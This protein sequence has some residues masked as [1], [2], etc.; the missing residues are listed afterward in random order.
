MMTGAWFA[1]FAVATAVALIATPLLARYSTSHRRWRAPLATAVGPP[2]AV[3]A[4]LPLT[5][6]DLDAVTAIALVGALWLWAA[7]Q[8]IDR[9]MLPSVLR[10]LAIGAAAALV[11]AAGLRLEVTGV[12]WA[13]VVVTVIV[14]WAATSAWRSAETR[15]GLLLG[16][17]A[18][19]AAGAALL[20]GL[21][22][23]ADI[24]ELGFA[25]V[26]AS[27]GFLAYVVPPV[28]ARLRTGGA[29]F[30]GFLTIVLAIA[31]EPSIEPPIAA[32]ASLLLIALP[33]TDGV[34]TRAARLRGHGRDAHHLGLAGRW[35]A[36]GLSRTATTWGLVV[37]QA[38]LVFV[39][40]LV[41]RGVLDPAPALL[42][43]IVLLG[44]VVVPA[45]FA[46]TGASR[47]RWPR[48]LLGLA[49]VAVGAILLLAAPAALALL[50]ARSDTTAAASA[51]ER[52]LAAARRGE[53]TAAE[54][55]FA[56]AARG[57]TAARQRLNDPAASLG[58][59]IPVLGPNLRAARD[60]VDVG[61]DLAQAGKSLASTADPEQLRI[62]D[63]TVNLAEL[64]RLQPEFA[65]AARLLESAK[66]R[67]DD[68]DRALLVGPVDDAITKLDQRLGRAVRDSRTAAFASR[69]LPAILGGD[70]SR[71]YFL[72]VQNNAEGRAA[73]GLIGSYGEIIAEGGK[74]DL[75]TFDRIATLNPRTPDEPRTLDAPPDYV[76]RYG[77]FQ[78][79]RL[80]QNV[81]TSPDVP[82]IG[83]IEASLLPQSGFGPVDGVVTIDPI[84]LASVLRITGPITVADWPEPITAEN[85]VDVTMRQAYIEYADDGDRRETFLGDVADAAWTAFSDRDLGSP[86]TVIKALS[87]ATRTKHLT[88]WFANPEDQALA[89]RAHAD[90][91]LPRAPA[92]LALVTT[93]NAGQ[94]KIDYFLQ[95]HLDYDLELFPQSGRSVDARGHLATTLENTAP[96]E[97]LPSYI[98][99]P[100]D[101]RFTA[102]ENLAFVTAY[103]ALRLTGATLDGQLQG[104]EAQRELGRWAYSNYVSI[105]ALSQRTLDL[106]LEGRLRLTTGG[107]YE[108][109]LAT[110]PSVKPD[111]ADISLRLP[112]G[113]RFAHADGLKI[114]D[115]GRR[116]TFTGTLD[117]DRLLRVRI[118]RDYGTSVWG[119]LQQGE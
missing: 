86:A 55:A 49:V 7:G 48:W 109:E 89:R 112:E 5:I 118:E 41:G 117:R 6:A 77:R 39:G 92:D 44:L 29:L 111:T 12:G 14:V 17:A 101:P 8:L 62:V 54:E 1:A 74:L 25:V 108:L 59:Q 27:F 65:S 52:G 61:V 64:E 16:W 42:G 18:V 60:L 100:N 88:M 46:R 97:G 37:I 73:G 91:A 79:E 116:A 23:Q 87:R 28:A 94:N 20:G 30:L 99:G 115:G 113:W 26:G 13:D 102:G 106:A 80:W 81:N 98:I 72:A 56:E 50:R 66:Q 4:T 69:V 15:D 82:T 31:A 32:L 2:L 76:R 51:A 96:A 119:Q 24:S 84:G 11:A 107:W 57:F 110:Q 10:R 58:L 75:G 93:G 103:S 35:R 36:L 63:A 83:Q 40:L 95:R 85:V 43:A 45:L 22:G 33:L 38:G 105:P 90:G 67:V 53:A 19:T 47:G 9:R 70:G 3:V 104:L 114:R 78:P 21:G 34:I 71:R 68:I